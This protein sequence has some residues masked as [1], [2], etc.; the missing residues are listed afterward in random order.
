MNR[1]WEP[2]HSAGTT[3]RVVDRS[4]WWMKAIPAGVLGIASFT[5]CSGTSTAF[6]PPIKVVNKVESVEVPPVPPPPAIVPPVVPPVPPP[7]FVPPPPPPPPP[8]IPPVPPVPPPPPVQVTP[9]PTAIVSA[10]IGL[11]IAAGWRLRRKNSKN[12]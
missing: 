9:E 5:I 6:F 1:P 4:H 12:D 3:T 7:P 10:G 8:A 2:I 11:A